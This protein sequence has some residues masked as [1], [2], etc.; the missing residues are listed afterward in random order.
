MRREQRDRRSLSRQQRFQVA[1]VIRWAFAHGN[2]VN[3]LVS[4]GHRIDDAPFVEANPP[5]FVSEILRHFELLS[6][7]WPWIAGQSRNFTF[8]SLAYIAREFLISCMASGVT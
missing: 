1:V 3:H 2:Y 5:D 8:D 7:C 4:V 6:A